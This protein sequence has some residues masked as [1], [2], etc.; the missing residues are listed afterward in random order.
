[1]PASKKTTIIIAVSAESCELV[2]QLVVAL[3]GALAVVDG[4]GVA[5]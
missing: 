4:I 2:L 5:T 1:M 3:L